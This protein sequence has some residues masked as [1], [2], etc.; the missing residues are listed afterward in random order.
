MDENAETTL[1]AGIDVQRDRIEI[2]GIGWARVGY[3]ASYMDLLL[4]KLGPL[5]PRSLRPTSPRPWLR[6]KKGRVAN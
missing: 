1:V 6:H 4:S 3:T 5:S 2:V